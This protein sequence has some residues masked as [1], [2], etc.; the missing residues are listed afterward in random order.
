MPQD[1][2]GEIIAAL[3]PTDSYEYTD[4]YDEQ[5]SA[6][7]ATMI[8]VDFKAT[9]GFDAPSAWQLFRVAGMDFCVPQPMA[10]V[11]QYAN[12]ATRNGVSYEPDDKLVH[13]RGWYLEAPLQLKR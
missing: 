2:G 8:A 11:P 10:L 6:K 5:G 13:R 9:A 1:Q 3:L 12:V 4:A 7:V